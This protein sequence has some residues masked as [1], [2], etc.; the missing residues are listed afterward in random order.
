MNTKPYLFL[1]Y[2]QAD[3]GFALHLA[4]DLKN[5]GMRLFADRLNVRLGEDRAALADQAFARAAG[6]L[7]VISP[8]CLQDATCREQLETAL[9]QNRHVVTILRQRLSRAGL[10]S[11]PPVP[12]PFDF[13]NP[14]LYLKQRA[15]LLF[16]LRQ[17]FP[18]CVHPA[19]SQTMRY[20][21]GL[22]AGLERANLNALNFQGVGDT[23][24]LDP[25]RW[26]LGQ[27]FALLPVPGASPP[28]LEPDAPLL[29]DV[30]HL[31]E[32]HRRVLLVGPPGSGKSTI[33]RQLALHAAWHCLGNPDDVRIPI[34]IRAAD[35]TADVDAEAFICAHW[36][37]DN[38][39]IKLLA[40][41]KAILFL[42][43]IGSGLDGPDRAARLQDWLADLTARSSAANDNLALIATCSQAI[44]ERG[45]PLR[46]PAARMAPPAREW[47]TG[48]VNT[49]MPPAEADCVLS[50]VVWDKYRAASALPGLQQYIYHPYL[51]PLLSRVCAEDGP[52]AR[53][54][55]GTLLDRMVGEL[56]ELRADEATVSYAALVEGLCA[57]AQAAVQDTMPAYMPRDYAEQKLANP[58]LLAPEN[59]AGFLIVDGNTVRFA[60]YL[61]LVYFAAR[62]L[63]GTP[64]Q[65]LVSDP[66]FNAAEQ[67]VSKALDPVIIMLAALSATP[68]QTVT[69]V[70]SIDA[71]L[72][73]IC[74]Y[75]GLPLAQDTV[76]ALARRLLNSPY[77]K[78]R[79]GRVSAVHLLPAS[80]HQTGLP[81]LLETM[82]SGTW[83]ARRVA[84]R[85]LLKLDIVALP[86]IEPTLD[87]LAANPGTSLQW[88]RQ[89]GEAA[90]PSLLHILARPTHDAARTGAIRA[91][92]RL[93]D[94]AAMPALVEALQDGDENIR[95]E[96]RE[97]I[98]AIRDPLVYQPISELLFSR[99]TAIREAAHATLAALGTDALHSLLDLA[100]TTSSEDIRTHTI[101]ALKLIGPP[102]LQPHIERIE[103]GESRD[104]RKA[105]D[106]RTEGTMI[107]RLIASLDRSLRGGARTATETDAQA[108]RDGTRAPHMEEREAQPLIHNTAQH[109]RERL[110]QIVERPR[111]DPPAQE[112]AGGD[113]VDQRDHLR[114]L[115][116]QPAETAIPQLAAALAD[117]DPAVRTTAVQTLA[118]FSTHEAAIEV[119]F[120][121]LAD[122]EAVVCDTAA[123]MLRAVGRPA[124]PYLL[125]AL[126]SDNVNMRGLAVEQLGKIGD[127]S[128]IASLADCLDDEAIPYLYKDRICDLAATALEQIGTPESLHIVLR[129]KA[130]RALDPRDASRYEEAS[131]E[132][133]SEQEAT[134]QVII[135]DQLQRI[136]NN[137]MDDDS[138]VQQA[139]ARE[140][141]RYAKQ[142]KKTGP[143]APHY[144]AISNQIV[145]A[146]RVSEWTVRWAAAEALGWIANPG[147]IPALVAL[148][149]DEHWI[150]R[151]AAL[152]ALV[153]MADTSVVP[154]IAELLDDPVKNV[155]ETA[156]SVI[157]EL[158]GQS[159]LAATRL[160]AA[161]ADPDE[162][163]RLA[164]IQ[165]LGQLQD[166]VNLEQLLR[167]LE[168][169]PV[170][171]RW[172]AA[173]A[174]QRIAAPESVPGLIQALTDESGPYFEERKVCHV[175][176]E[177][178]QAIGTPEALSALA[179]WEQEQAAYQGK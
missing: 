10:E 41:G 169:G 94:T 60:H 96:A 97:A 29:P 154:Y 129:W 33:L 30:W 147:T 18:D 27:P 40:G 136:L 170:N 155:R 121:A 93:G 72:A 141:R 112:G 105:I 122:E 69:Q 99:E 54:S 83:K 61:L 3:A 68:D 151:V 32:Q 23:L 140:L 128:V 109:A 92:A 153:E 106:R 160:G 159:T 89:L 165:A 87:Q 114:S 20:L 63:Q 81:L 16:A 166:R 178:L 67:R 98:C 2:T 6:V 85:L 8:A 115:A 75:G 100:R 62:A 179:Y 21:N 152:R 171:I 9:Q 31:V 148:L 59:S 145:T 158:G 19:P 28:L 50:Q 5:Q 90:L 172:A 22:I 1:V 74:V 163:V 91:L 49:L 108:G 117:S 24:W 80:A 51:L 118:V 45:L 17:Q 38:D 132:V 77:V 53:Y 161:L 12:D 142:L 144:V 36:P 133:L 66:I 131:V 139:A 138:F 26:L 101:S 177:A 64:L 4:A 134:E 58:A 70:A 126:E 116:R 46:L 130:E 44:Y 25:D 157:G 52:D 65:T 79:Q 73:M 57:L 135:D 113:Y 143:Q 175:A 104:P 76:T 7:V 123:D 119:L 162:F 137:L 14:E 156:A 84:T 39:P 102:Y 168:N 110:K 56:W 55:I 11:L 13:T 149:E 103:T 124:I 125:R 95:M 86:E 174:L 42:D 37:L 47:L 88:L 107:K 71:F 164:A 176:A 35:W 15:E 120:S 173:E 111:I 146:T 48:L 43:D 127:P 82:R 34:F 78:N 167:A 150:V